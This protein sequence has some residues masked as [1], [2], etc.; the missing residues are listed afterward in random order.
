M[1]TPN[2]CSCRSGVSITPGV[3]PVVSFHERLEAEV[4][5]IEVT[6][7]LNAAESRTLTLYP[8]LQFDEGRMWY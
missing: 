5:V 1:A 4:A 2:A 3:N 6:N 7:C 8:E